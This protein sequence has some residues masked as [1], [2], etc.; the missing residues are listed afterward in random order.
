MRTV[1]VATA[2]LALFCADPWA[3]AAAELVLE[4]KQEVLYLDGLGNPKRWGPSECTVEASRD[5]KADGRPTVHVHMPVDHF[6]G[7]KKYPIGWPRMYMKLRKPSE[8]SWDEFERFEFMFYARMSRPKPPPQVATFHI[9]CPDRRKATYHRFRKIELNKWITVSVPIRQ[10][11]SL[12]DLVRLGLNISESNYKHGD[13][14]DFYL[15]GFRLV[16]S[17]EF[18]VAAM[19]IRA[20]VVYRGQP[21]LRVELHVTG[22]LARISRGVPFT[23]RQGKRVLRKE[24][25]PVRMG[26][27]TL[28]IDIGELKL[29]PGRYSLVAFEGAADRRKAGDFRVVEAPWSGQK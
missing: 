18:S 16:R 12:P 2:L 23:V 1:I 22:P 13:K 6:G 5:L 14:V 25:L 27:Q 10:I 19:K 29:G 17:A 26:I 11:K 4:G 28:Q 3:Q 21:K 24:T 15:G 20:A 7:E 9:L 8:T